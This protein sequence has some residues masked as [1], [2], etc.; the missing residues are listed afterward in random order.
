M[1]N[2]SEGKKRRKNRNERD[3]LKEH[4]TSQKKESLTKDLM[5]FQMEIAQFAWKHWSKMQ[6]FEE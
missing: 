3:L 5:S 4:L 6:T 1:K 2:E